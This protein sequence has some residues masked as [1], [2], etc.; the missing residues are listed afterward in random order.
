ML[1]DDDILQL[2]MA[3][4]GCVSGTLEEWPLLNAA[5]K[6][7]GRNLPLD[8]MAPMMRITSL[9]VLEENMI[10]WRTWMPTKVRDA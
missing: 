8:T 1:T 2:I 4:S 7:A 6:T 5:F 9:A 3:A 10:D